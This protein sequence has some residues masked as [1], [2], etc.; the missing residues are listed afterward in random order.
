MIEFERT[1]DSELVKRIMTHPRVYPSISDDF[2]PEASD[3]EPNMHPSIWYVLA[4]DGEQLLGLWMFVPQNAICWEVHTCLLP[5]AWGRRAL[6]AVMAL[7]DWV[8]QNTPCLRVITNVP[9]YNTLA[10]R[11]A[12]KAGLGIF[13]KNWSSF[14]KHGV[15]HDQI[16]LG[17]SKPEGK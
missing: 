15:L 4:R 16:M 10:L 13:G 11:F 1:Y 6:E 12:Q 8:W 9:R 7:H 14:M 2:C 5:E 17:I 3:F